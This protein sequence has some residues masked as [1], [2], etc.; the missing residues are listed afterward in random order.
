MGMMEC[1]IMT[2]RCFGSRKMILLTSLNPFTLHITT[3]G[4]HDY[5]EIQKGPNNWC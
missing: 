1:W 4:S 3:V 2:D 5:S